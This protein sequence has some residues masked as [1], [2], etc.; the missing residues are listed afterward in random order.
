VYA[1]FDVWDMFVLAADVQLRFKVS[2]YETSGTFEIAISKYVDDP[3]A[4]LAIYTVD[5]L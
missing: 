4:L 2:G 1:S 5:F 3:K